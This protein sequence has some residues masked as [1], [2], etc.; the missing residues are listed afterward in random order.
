M[1][2]AAAAQA[3]AL[4]RCITCGISVVSW[5]LVRL[6]Q[7]CAQFGMSPRPFMCPCL[8]TVGGAEAVW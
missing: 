1:A 8:R 5:P 7:G 4:V 6:H 2:A 3:A